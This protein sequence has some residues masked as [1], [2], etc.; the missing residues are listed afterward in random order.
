M[1]GNYEVNDLTLSLSSGISSVG[2][3]TL[4]VDCLILHLI[5]VRPFGLGRFASWEI[6]LTMSILLDLI[7]QRNDERAEC[8]DTLYFSMSRCH[9][10]KLT[11][12]VALYSSQRM[13]PSR[14]W[15]VGDRQVRCLFLLAG[16]LVKIRILF[17]LSLMMSLSEIWSSWLMFVEDEIGK[18]IPVSN[19]D[20]V[21]EAAEDWGL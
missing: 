13:M 10:Y 12:F 16:N 4:V 8:K 15:V 18:S 5:G 1:I 21:G 14:R 7:V 2:C 17:G 6:D 20:Y 3:V 11:H 9:S 19:D